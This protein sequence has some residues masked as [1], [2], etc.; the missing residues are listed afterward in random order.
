[1]TRGA[2]PQAAVTL[3]GEELSPDLEPLRPL[4]EG[5]VGR[6][7]LARE[8]A[9]R[10]LVAI[11][12]LRDDL[13]LDDNVR[14]RFEREAKA[15]ASAS[16]RN[17]TTV[18]RVGHLADGRPFIV[19]EYIEGRTLED[20]IAAR[21]ALS[22]REAVDV[23]R[24]V[25]SAL[26]AAHAQRVVHRD[27]R[28][29]NVM[30]EDGTGRVVL[31]DFGLAAL[32][33]T[34]VERVTRLTRAGET[35]GDPWHM[36]PEQLRGEQATGASDVWGLGVM[37][38][39]LLT[40]TNPFGEGTTATRLAA[41]LAGDGPPMLGAA[42]DP[43]L[44]RLL[45]EC[46]AREPGRRPRAAE[47]VVVLEQIRGQG[48]ASV[49]ADTH[50]SGRDSANALPGPLRDFLLELKRRKVYRTGAAYVAVS[51]LVLQAADLLSPVLTERYAD[52]WYRVI[53]AV[54]MAG[55]PVVLVM[56]WIFDLDGRGSADAAPPLPWKR[57]VLPLAGLAASAAIAVAVWWLLLR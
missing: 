10:R 13:A 57:R 55:F 48:S 9:L 42:I 18:H 28:P 38:Y 14:R 36:S 44:G 31:M 17:I 23:L 32:L 7:F 12:V 15:A 5:S 20:Q 41:I 45:R 49:Q 16:H 11:K 40:G 35:L 6:V 33:E 3:L 47:V 46:L 26:A 37:G 34:G 39:E 2:D 25:A 22:V 53:V 43:R 19:M 50:A 56:S 29:A 27:V 54:T 21:G 52:F 51:F 24:A 8:P 1:M 30:V 4:G